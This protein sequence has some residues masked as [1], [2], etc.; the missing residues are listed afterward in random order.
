M[1]DE[2]NIMKLFKLK[3][4]TTKSNLVFQILKLLSVPIVIVSV[5][6]FTGSL[7]YVNNYKSLLNEFYTNEMTSFIKSVSDEFT[8]LQ[9]AGYTLTL[10]PNINY[11]ITSNN[12]SDPNSGIQAQK[13]QIA[14]KNFQ[15]KNDI[16]D[17]VF[18]LNF[19]S[20]TVISTIGV[21]NLN[22][23]FDDI[24]SYEKYNHNFWNN[25]KMK[26]NMIRILDYT[27]VSTNYNERYSVVP[28]VFIPSNTNNMIVFNIN[29]ANLFDKFSYYKFTEN[30]LHYMISI[31]GLNHI[32][33]STYPLQ[34][35]P[36]NNSTHLNYNTEDAIINSK[37]YF[38]IS[39][40]EYTNLFSH[41][42]ATAIPY[43]DIYKN[44]SHITSGLAII[45]VLII[46]ILLLIAYFTSI[47]L[48]FPWDALAKNLKIDDEKSDYQDE[49]VINYVNKSVQNLLDTNNHLNHSLATALPLSQQ[50][51][52]TDL[53]NSPSSTPDYEIY[54]TIFKYN[55]FASIAINISSRD[56]NFPLTPNLQ[57]SIYEAVQS[58]F[59]D[60]FLTF[61]LPSTNNSLYLL[62]NLEDNTYSEKLN[63]IIDSVKELFTCDMDHINLNIGAG[64]IYKGLDGLRVT[65]QEALSNIINEMNSDRILISNKLMQAYSLI[66]NIEN[67]L[68]NY[69]MA[70][71]NE[72][73]IEF[74]ETTFKIH[75]KDSLKYKRLLYTQIF[76]AFNK[77]IQVKKK[78]VLDFNDETKEE[79]KEQLF[80]KEEQDI[81]EYF[82]FLVNTL[83]S[84]TTPTLKADISDIMKYIQEHYTE[85]LSLEFLA[86]HFHLSSTYL[87]KHLKKHI[88][89]SFKEYV[90]QLRTN[91]AKE[92]LV[93]HPEMSIDQIGKALGLFSPSAFTKMFK[94][95]MGISPREYR[96]L[97][98]KN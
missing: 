60:Y 64:N 84:D 56:D 72:K 9:D 4:Y 8:N 74:L 53:L 73:T 52:L 75:S 26:N 48:S 91:K 45:S 21:Y 62:L 85:D 93:N 38:V 97:Y 41:R 6:V 49:N 86:Q 15:S 57:R 79:F 46:L 3:K 23:F 30:T 71:Y 19:N 12:I 80:S 94:K 27:N 40:S 87:S 1:I 63:S 83:T 96:S 7:Y 58:V 17:N 90:T 18:I 88:G 82:K 24:Y 33:N 81:L 77:A 67:T 31:D 70:N 95:S 76:S 51:F 2:V 22:S 25:I 42:F 89:L 43:S 36:S 10:D 66:N 55:Y 34:L 65:H 5:F 61:C 68:F 16:L 78:K 69:I 37:R 39:S 44:S 28:V 92:L 50:K 54:N 47:K 35:K 29:L 20:N 98:S 59:A 11:A 13:T 14:L 32:T